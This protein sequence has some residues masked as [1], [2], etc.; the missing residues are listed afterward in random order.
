[1]SD[2]A[3]YDQ[4]HALAATLKRSSVYADLRLVAARLKAEK[5]SLDMLR[6][7]RKRQFGLQSRLLQGE[8]ISDED[9]QQFEQLSEIVA[10]H[11]V[12]S[13]FLRAEY[14]VSRLLA[15][16]QRILS[17]AVGDDL[18]DDGD[19]GAGAAA[20]AAGGDTGTGG[21]AK[22]GEDQVEAQAPKDEPGGGIGCGG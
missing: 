15:D 16:V 3:V 6:D 10:G 2:G 5:A 22:P 11:A 8:E 21:E 14:N 7:F 18:L 19:A 17:D 4:A 12:I 20:G 1:M 9:K 13:E